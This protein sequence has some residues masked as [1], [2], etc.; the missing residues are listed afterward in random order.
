MRSTMQPVNRNTEPKKTRDGCRSD[1]ASFD[2]EVEAMKPRSAVPTC[3]TELT[4]M[5]RL[6]SFLTRSAASAAITLFIAGTLPAQTATA[7]LAS[8][9]TSI[10][11]VPFVVGEELVFKATFGVLPA[12]TARMRVE[13]I[14]SIRGRAAY[15]LVFTIDG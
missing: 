5:F 13:G 11:P 3:T 15:H 8:Q 9:G 14:D 2:V 6:Q 12:G 4:T 7:A 1:D 10:A